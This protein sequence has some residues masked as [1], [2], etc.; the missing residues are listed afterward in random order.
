LVVVRVAVGVGDGV[1]V[2]VSVGARVLVCVGV[3]VRVNVLVGVALGVSVGSSVGEFVAADDGIIETRVCVGNDSLLLHPAK[4]N[5]L[6]MTNR[7]MT[8][9]MS[10]LF[11]ITRDCHSKKVGTVVP[12]LDVGGFCRVVERAWENISSSATNETAERCIR[13]ALGG[14]VCGKCFLFVFVDY[15]LG[16][17]TAA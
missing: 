17:D 6:N 1:N 12:I 14:S 8:R 10:F 3:A 9:R 7:K 13:F 2:A 11:A 4:I 15:A 5:A 16:N